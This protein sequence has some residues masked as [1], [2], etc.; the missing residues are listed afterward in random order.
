MCSRVRWIRVAS[1]L[2]ATVSLLVPVQRAH[3]CGPWG[4][5]AMG[6][7]TFDR[8]VNGC[9]GPVVGVYGDDGLKNQLFTYLMGRSCY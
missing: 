7:H 4:C 5:Y 6:S 8:G 2:L 1:I 9:F 3:A